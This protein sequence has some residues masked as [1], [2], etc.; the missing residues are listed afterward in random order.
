LKD[1]Y[2]WVTVELTNSMMADQAS[3]LPGVDRLDGRRI[4]LT[5]ED[6]LKAYTAFQAAVELAQT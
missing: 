3:I 1:N 4:E 5:A 2:N 6:M